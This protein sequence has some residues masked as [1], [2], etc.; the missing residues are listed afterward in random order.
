MKRA[1]AAAVRA[2]AALVGLIAAWPSSADEGAV[3]AASRPLDISNLFRVGL[4]YTDIHDGGSTI[5]LRLRL[6]IAYRGLLIPG[7]RVGRIYAL[8]RVDVI[9]QSL[10]SPA[11]R[12]VG[13]RNL[14]FFDLTGPQR[15]WGIFGVG[16][17]GALPTSTDAALGS[18]QLQLGPAAGVL[19]TRIPHV[20]LSLLLRSFLSVAA[21]TAS[22][23]ERALFV[24]PGVTWKLP[25]SF[26]AKTE[27]AIRFDW[28]AHETTVAV[29]LAAGH[30]VSKHLVLEVR[31]NAIVVG[32]G[33][34]NVRVVFFVEYVKW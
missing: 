6:R 7:L 30:A 27:E 25:R 10:Q 12:V 31:P 29:N 33:Q 21:A 1:P 22:E 20:E 32:R 2:L 34:G 23:Q 16:L 5:D 13:L 14:E 18:R 26:Y 4:A 3:A 17:S 19:V 28:R 24:E 9:V 15:G 11:A 8:V